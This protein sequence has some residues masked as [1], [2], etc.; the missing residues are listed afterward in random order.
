MKFMIASDIHGM[1][2]FCGKMLEAFEGEGADRLVL[3][4]D[5]LYNG[6]RNAPPEGYGAQD[7]AAML[8]ERAGRILCVRGNCDAE[9]DQ[10]VLKFPIMADYCLLSLG[11]RAVFVT[12]GHRFNREAW[13]PL[14]RG[15]ILLCGHTHIPAW[16]KFGDGN[17]YLNPGSVSLPKADAWRGYMLLTERE[18]V[19]KDLETG[20]ARYALTL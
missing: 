17:L 12:H 8:N 10:A 18:A 4:G 15:D 14:S 2:S 6:P 5:I 11:E 16:E 13:P 19:W 3:L 9:V 20:G 7:A 1:A